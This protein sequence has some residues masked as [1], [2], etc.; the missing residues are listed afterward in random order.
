MKTTREF[1]EL[2]I[3]LA[4]FSGIAGIAGTAAFGNINFLRFGLIACVICIGLALFWAWF[5]GK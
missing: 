3:L 5:E 1:D 2:F 4:F